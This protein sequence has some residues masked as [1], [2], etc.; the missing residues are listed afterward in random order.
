MNEEIS[1]RLHFIFIPASPFTA[2]SHDSTKNRFTQKWPKWRGQRIWAAPTKQPLFSCNIMM[3]N[4]NKY[5]HEA[6]IWASKRVTRRSLYGNA[7]G[8]SMCVRARSLFDVLVY[9]LHTFCA[10]PVFQVVPPNIVHYI[11]IANGQLEQQRA[12]SALSPQPGASFK[13]KQTNFLINVIQKAHLRIHP[14]C[15]ILDEQRRNTKKK[16]ERKTCFW[17]V[18]V[19]RGSGAEAE[20]Q[21]DEAKLKKDLKII[22]HVKH[23][24]MCVHVCVQV[25]V[26]WSEHTKT[27]INTHTKYISSGLPTLLPLEAMCVCVSFGV[28]RLVLSWLSQVDTNH[29]RIVHALLFRNGTTGM[30]GTEIFNLTGG[31][32][33]LQERHKT[34]INSFQVTKESHFVPFCRFQAI[35]ISI[36]QSSDENVRQICVCSRRQAQREK[37]CFELCLGKQCHC[38]THLDHCGSAAVTANGHFG[39]CP[40]SETSERQFRWNKVQKRPCERFTIRKLSAMERDALPCFPILCSLF[41]MAATFSA[42]M[43]RRVT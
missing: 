35:L 11:F 24:S 10:K 15:S 6:A 28:R 31:W 13:G 4:T 2:A 9:L 22:F 17:C 41:G 38:S 16:E 19:P 3:N 20:S 25:H 5:I 39:H 27:V 42:S 14:Q 36:L 37:W 12:S 43:P 7:A 23:R 8:G 29:E 34:H 30:S 21:R 18:C 32:R 40:T 33:L 1:N 26:D